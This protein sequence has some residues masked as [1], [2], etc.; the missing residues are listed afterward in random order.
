MTI[1]AID[2]QIDELRTARLMLTAAM[3]CRCPSVETCTCGA[4]DEAV[5]QMLGM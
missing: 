2:L 3:R 1:D 5:I 4:M